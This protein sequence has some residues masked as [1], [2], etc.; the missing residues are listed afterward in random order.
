MSPQI[1]PQKEKFTLPGKYLLFILTVICIILVV[2]TFT[3]DIF[4]KPLNYAVGSVIVPY[5]RGVSAI[6]RAL[7]DKKDEL[8]NVHDIIKEN[9]ELRE[10]VAYLEDENTKLMQ[11]KYEL[12]TLRSLYELDGSYESYSKIGAKVIYRESGNWFSSFIIDKGYKDG[13]APDMNVIAGNGL[14]GRVSVV[15]PNWSKITSIIADNSNV[16]ANVLKSNNNIIVSGDLEKMEDGVILFSQLIDTENNVSTGDK[17][18]TSSISDKYLPGILIGYIEDIE[19]DSN[20]LTKSGTI[21]TAVDFEHIDEV[22][23]ITELKQNVTKEDEEQGMTSLDFDFDLL[24][25]NND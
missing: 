6:G 11:D 20:N 23:I 13:V 10:K 18:V 16:S 7:S 24:E 12:N 4:N 1:K 17:I 22:L 8:V 14:V 19:D 9:E 2:V 3:T 21:I 5:Q 15:G 25:S